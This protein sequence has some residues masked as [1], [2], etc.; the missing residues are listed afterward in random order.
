MF[1]GQQ[2]NQ[3][4]ASHPSQRSGAGAG[5]ARTAFDATPLSVCNL[6]APIRSAALGSGPAAQTR[7]H[8]PADWNRIER[9]VERPHP[10][11]LIC[12]IGGAI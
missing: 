11:P 6:P 8:L 2:S 10:H 1:L 7:G 3:L 9:G 5:A 4:R 12:Q